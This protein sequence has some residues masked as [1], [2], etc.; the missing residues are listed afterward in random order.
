MRAG[1][2]PHQTSVW[3]IEGLLPYL[4]EAAVSHLFDKVTALS[5]PGSRLGFT[6]MNGEMLTSSAT[7][8]VSI[9][10]GEAGGGK[11]GSKGV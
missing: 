4:S 5:A 10:K 1:F 9:S 11:E 7:D 6:T 8:I 2:D 3:L